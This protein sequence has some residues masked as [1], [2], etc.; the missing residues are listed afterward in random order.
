MA[1]RKNGASDPFRWSFLKN[2]S[3]TV[4]G[5][6]VGGGIIGGLLGSN[7]TKG[8]AETH[9]MVTKMQGYQSRLIRSQVFVLG[10]TALQDEAQK[11]YKTGFHT[12]KPEEQEGKTNRMEV[13]GYVSRTMPFLNH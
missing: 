3:F 7:K 1:D 4:G 12:S 5:A 10:F 6:V 9:T 2:A 13:Y 11:R 8:V